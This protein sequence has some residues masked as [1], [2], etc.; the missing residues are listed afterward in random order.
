MSGEP[1]TGHGFEE[2]AY[3]VVVVGAE[4]PACRRSPLTTRGHAPP[5]SASPSSGRHTVM[6]EGGIAAAMGN[7]WAEDNWRVHFRDTMRGG[8]MLNS[9]R[10]AQLHARES[11]E[12]VIELEEW[13]PSSTGPTMGSSRSETAI[14]TRGSPVGDHRAGDDPHPPTARVA[15]GIDVYMEHGHRPLEG[16]RISGA[17][18]YWRETGRFIVFKTPTVV[19]ATGEIGKSY[20]VTSNS[21][22]YTGDGHALA[23]RAGRPRQHGVRPVHLPGWSGR[24]RCAASSMPSPCAATVACCA[25][26]GKRFMFD[27]IPIL[28]GRDGRHGGGGGPLV[29][30]QDQQPPT[31]RAASA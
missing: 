31:T 7:L 6:A 27:Y 9:W 5:S 11:P 14:A 13:A 22:E 20:Q 24:R 17:F 15:L 18:A 1:D 8:K 21:W 26:R 3:D 10:M 4:A 23:L 25:T 29:R 2:H 12:R 16:R 28:Q 30:R 19:L